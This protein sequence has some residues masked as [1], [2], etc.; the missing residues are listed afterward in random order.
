MMK[1]ATLVLS[2]YLVLSPSQAK[3]TS[4]HR[5]FQFHGRLVSKTQMPTRN[6]LVFAV[7]RAQRRLLITNE[8]SDDNSDDPPGP[9]ELDLQSFYARPRINDSRKNVDSDEV[10]PYIAIRLALAR[11]KALKKYRETRA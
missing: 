2:L 8:L 3:T 11:E 4:D 7:P 9:D 5:V 10:S 6:V 1:L